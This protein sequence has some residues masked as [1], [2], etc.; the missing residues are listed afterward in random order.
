MTATEQP[1]REIELK[2]WSTLVA[3][4]ALKGFQLWR[5]DAADGPTRY[6]LARWGR[7]RAMADVEEV[8]R[9]LEVVGAA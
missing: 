1:S 4:A 6:F 3:R 2:A 5:S 8:E 9:I 7:V